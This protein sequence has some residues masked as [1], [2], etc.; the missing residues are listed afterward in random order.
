MTR[1]ISSTMQAER[2]DLHRLWM[3]LLVISILLA[4][5]WAGWATAGNL[6]V[7]ETS[8]SV[9]LT[10]QGVSDTP[11]DPKARTRKAPKS[12]A[13]RE[14][15]FEARFP[16]TARE[17]LAPSQRAM[18][19]LETDTGGYIIPAE[20]TELRDDAGQ[21]R[22]ILRADVGESTLDLAAHALPKRVRV[23]VGARTPLDLWLP[24]Q[25]ARRSQVRQ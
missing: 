16:A 20:I 13:P 19:S 5:A 22:V 9:K 23:E 6:V 12:H 1:P 2:L 18:I 11:L 10:E 21:I 17:S 7:Y 15:W 24:E 14:R 8:E 25:A 4:L 3:V